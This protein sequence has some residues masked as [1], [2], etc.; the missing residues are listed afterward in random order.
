MFQP[1]QLPLSNWWSIWLGAKHVRTPQPEPSVSRTTQVDVYPLACSFAIRRTTG[2]LIKNG[3]GWW[4]FNSE[5][6]FQ[7]YVGKVHAILER[8]WDLFIYA[9]NVGKKK[10][11]VEGKEGSTSP[12]IWARRPNQWEKEGVKVLLAASLMWILE[13]FVLILFSWKAKE[14]ATGE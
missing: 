6:N 7:A 5:R 1:L 12:Q 11:R 4:S 2:R 3:L 14:E 10:E 13:L 9:L 8:I